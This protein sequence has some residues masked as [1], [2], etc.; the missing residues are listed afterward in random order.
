MITKLTNIVLGLSLLICVTG[1]NNDD[2]LQSEYESLPKDRSMVFANEE[3][4]ICVKNILND[5]GVKFH[6]KTIENRTW[7]IIETGKMMDYVT[8]C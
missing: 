4:F 7:L 2:N 5:K 1:C 3:D 6:E 8:Q